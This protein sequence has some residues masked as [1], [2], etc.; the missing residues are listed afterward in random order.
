MSPTRPFVD[1]EGSI[2]IRRVLDEARTLASLVGF[3]VAASLVPLVLV[4][5]G[6]VIP[7]LGVLFLALAY[8]VLVIGGGIVLM[9]VIARGMQLSVK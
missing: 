7:G 6:G 8:V 9:Y 5:V 4:L 3:V 1:S 2:D